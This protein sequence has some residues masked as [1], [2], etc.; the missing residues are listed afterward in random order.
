MGDGAGL[1]KELNPFLIDKNTEPSWETEVA[2]WY[3]IKN[4]KHY[5]VFRWDSKKDEYDRTYL[6]LDK[7]TNQPVRDTRLLEGILCLF[8]CLETVKERDERGT[9]EENGE[10]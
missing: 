2:K 6:L 4:G 1:V 7:E 3:L 9:D 10:A 8:D 5:A